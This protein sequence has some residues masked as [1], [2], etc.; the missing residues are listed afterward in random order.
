M[1]ECEGDGLLSQESYFLSDVC[2]TPLSMLSPHND[3]R[4]FDMSSGVD[5]FA[6]DGYFMVVA[7]R[8]DIPV[9]MVT[10]L[11]LMFSVMR[12]KC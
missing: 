3:F 11:M 2:I 7:F 12:K 1:L 6:F 5:N 8:S 9:V 10:A 4:G